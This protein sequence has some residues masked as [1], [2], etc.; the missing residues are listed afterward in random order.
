MEQ[1]LVL[2]PESHVTLL[3]TNES[4]DVQNRILNC[5]N[6]LLLTNYFICFAGGSY[7]Q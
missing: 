6:L 2:R 3:A 7:G 4:D 5:L 1:T